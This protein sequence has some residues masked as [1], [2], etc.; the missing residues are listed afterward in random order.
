MNDDLEKCF[1]YLEVEIEVS[2]ACAED[3][4]NDEVVKDL[5]RIETM[6]LSIRGKDETIKALREQNRKLREAL[7]FYADRDYIGYDV[8]VTDYGI[9]LTVGKVIK[10]AGNKAR[11]ALEASASMTIA[12]GET[13]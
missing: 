6:L 5:R 3:P 10:D 1:A 8:E 11:A 13:E 7:E 12:E 9:S 2:K 4:E